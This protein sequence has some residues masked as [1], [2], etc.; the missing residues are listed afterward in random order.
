ML[1]TSNDHYRFRDYSYKTLHILT[2]SHY[3]NESRDTPA[4]APYSLN[5]L[6]HVLEA[7]IFVSKK[8]PDGANAF[9]S[10]LKRVCI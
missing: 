2:R 1:S 3:A 9:I 6:I 10:K 5:V 8:P 4:N 7:S